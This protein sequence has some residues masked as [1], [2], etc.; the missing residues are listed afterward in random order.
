MHPYSADLKKVA[1]H[2]AELVRR[3][4]DAAEGAQWTDSATQMRRFE[5]LTDIGDLRAATVLDLGCNTGA[6]YGFLRDHRGFRGEYVGYDV[7]EPAILRARQRFPGVR[8]ELR[9][10]LTEGL[11]RTFDFI[12]MSGVFNNQLSDN[13]GLLHEVLRTL[14]PHVKVGLAFNLM[15]SYVDYREE[16]LAY[17]DP[18]PVF[19]FCKETL[20]PRVTLRHDYLVKP[21][22]VPFEFTIYVYQSALRCRKRSWYGEGPRPDERS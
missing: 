18:E 4:P 11:D 21:D 1:A 15:S 9:D 19:H 7:A 2:Y 22:I 17:F 12:L 20:S 3:Y 5:I 6:L 10:I 13:Q 8:F 14:Y 16:D